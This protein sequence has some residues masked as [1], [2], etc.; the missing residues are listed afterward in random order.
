MNGT[1]AFSAKRPSVAR[2]DFGERESFCA[3]VPARSLASGGIDFTARTCSRITARLGD[4]FEQRLGTLRQQIVAPGI[5]RRLI[6]EFA[7]HAQC[8]SASLDVGGSG[9]GIH[10]TRR[11]Q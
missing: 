2:T 11:H 10:T 1:V 4:D 6:Y 8:T 9:R 5:E 7:A 3:I